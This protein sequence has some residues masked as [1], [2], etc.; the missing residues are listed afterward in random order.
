MKFEIEIDSDNAAFSHEDVVQEIKRILDKIASELNPADYDSK[1]IMDVNGNKVGSWYFEP[2]E[3]DLV[4]QCGCGEEWTD[5]G[6][7]LEPD[8]CPDPEC[9]ETV[10]PHADN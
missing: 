5:T 10:T 2:T 6:Y 3:L 7:T 1:S 9:A 8:T 4:Y